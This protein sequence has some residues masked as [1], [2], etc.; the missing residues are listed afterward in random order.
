MLTLFLDF[1]GVLHPSTVFFE[2]GEVVLLTNDPALSLFCWASVLEGLLDEADPEATIIHVIISSTWAHRFGWKKAAA[3]LPD[4]LSRRVIGSTG[5]MPAPRGVQVEC[6]AEDCGITAW[7]ALDDDLT[8]W[9]KQ[10][11]HRLVACPAEAG[12][13]AKEPQEALRLKLKI[14]LNKLRQ[15]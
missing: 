4:G 2:N 13:A 15:S 5:P 8:G 7:L 12:L 11:S 6:F 9:T 3:Y 1:D 10:H 14:E